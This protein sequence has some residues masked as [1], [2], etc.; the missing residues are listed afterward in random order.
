MILSAFVESYKI[1]S[2]YLFFF[3]FYT[4]LSQKYRT[5]NQLRKKVKYINRI[6]RKKKIKPLTICF[7]NRLPGYIP[8]T[9]K[10]MFSC[11]ITF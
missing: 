11:Y 8:F 2:F 1:F 6:N 5:S 7:L 4:S 3:F 10:Y 9:I